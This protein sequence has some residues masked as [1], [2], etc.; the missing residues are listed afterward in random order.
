MTYDE[1]CIQL[2]LSPYYGSKA[3]YDQ[4]PETDHATDELINGKAA[5]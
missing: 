1:T 2:R 4:M 3:R 5:L